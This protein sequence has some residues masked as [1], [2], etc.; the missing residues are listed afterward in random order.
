MIGQQLGRYHIVENLGE[1][2]MAAVYKGFDNRLRRDVAI[3]VI[4]RGFDQKDVFIKRFEREAMAVAQLTHPNIVRVIDYG[5]EDGVPYLVMEYIPGGTL[6]DR[7]GKA[8][9]WREAAKMLIPVARALDYAHKENII[10]R[11]IKPA[12]ILVTKSGDLML[13]DFGIAKTLDADNLTKLTGTG[14]GIGTP[15][16]MAPEQGMGRDIDQRVDIYSLGVVFY[17]MITG[18]PP[19]EADTPMAVMLKHISDPLPRPKSFV[20]DIPEQ[21]EQILFKAL[22]KDPDHRFQDMGEFAQALENLVRSKEP[23]AAPVIET[24]V[25]PILAKTVKA[26]AVQPGTVTQ[27]APK[28]RSSWI[29]YAW[30]P[31]LASVACVG[32]V[33]ILTVPKLLG[34][35]APGNSSPPTKVAEVP[36]PTEEIEI[37]EPV[38]ATDSPLPNPEDNRPSP[39]AAISTSMPEPSQTASEPPSA[40]PEPTLEQTLG[41]GSQGI[42]A[43]DQAVMMYIPAGS[44][45]R[46][47]NDRMISTLLDQCSRC[48]SRNF[49]DATPMGEIYLDAF[50]IYQTE[51]TNAQY[52][53][54]VE[55]GSCSPPDDF[56]SRTRTS[57]YG[58]PDFDSYPVVYVSWA[59]AGSYCRWI[60]GRLPTE[61]EWEKAAR[62][63]D[64]RLYPWGDNA[65]RGANANVERYVGDTT[66]VASYPSGKSPYGLYDMAGNVYEWVIDW[67][68]GSYYGDAPSQNPYGPQS[69]ATHV[70]RGGSADYREAWATT[71][72]RDYLDSAD[73]TDQIGF[74]CVIEAQP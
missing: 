71:V 1:G 61:A 69:G 27:A 9:P 12:N 18:R 13:S 43:Q 74:R 3:K 6:K 58:N 38:P 64:G 15:A 68:S 40:T 17:E 14:V 33:A 21:V 41:I 22:A 45:T 28:P 46:G 60:G 30:I 32:L 57:Y 51:V 44:F 19:Y 67:Y 42:S 25:E 10:H 66:A 39:E 4:L 8:V 72:F 16:Y 5:T 31:V 36:S 11:D 34:L 53:L 24:A 63:T 2:G 7:M 55:A 47:V 65:S 48:E 23:E 73:S 54:C 29:K 20:P 56:S 37:V 70:I 62:G 50:W 35:I 49:A 59:D 26:P 52:R